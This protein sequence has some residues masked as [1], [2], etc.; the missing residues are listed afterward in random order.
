[1]ADSFFSKE[2]CI[3]IKKSKKLIIWDL[4]GVI[5]DTE[6]IWMESR[7]K[8]LNQKFGINWTIYETYQY[9]GGM[10]WKT[11][12]QTLNNMGICVDESF[13]KEAIELDYK[14]LKDGIN[15][16]LGIENIFSRKDIKQ[17]IAT[18]GTYER[19]N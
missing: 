14:L 10:S 5:A 19:K 1:M 17:C 13:E 11:R 3:V 2:S 12:L 18:G 16:T 7:Q 6:S 4:D 15:L 9:I 8:L